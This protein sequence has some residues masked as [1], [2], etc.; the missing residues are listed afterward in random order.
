[1]LDD[2]SRMVLAWDL[3]LDMTAESIGEIVEQAVAFTGMRGVP[4]EDK[5]KLL[6]DNGPGYIAK[7][8]E[9]YLRM[10][11]IHHIRPARRTM[12]RPT[13][14]WSAFSRRGRPGSTCWSTAAR[15]R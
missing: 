13:A 7:V 8:R 11:S 5:T 3:M 12:R 9:D 10:P 14:S 4:V 2:F 15:R 1:M 6:T